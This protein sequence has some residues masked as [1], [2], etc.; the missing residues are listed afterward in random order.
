MNPDSHDLLQR[1]MAGL[2]TDDEAAVLQTRLKADTDL[3]RLYLHYMNLDVALEAQAGSRD[4]VIDLL[5]S[6]PLMESKPASRWH[7]WRP[8]TAAAAGLVFGLFSASMVWAYALP[9]AGRAVERTVSVLTEGFE[10]ADLTASRGFPRQANE[11][12][13]DVSAPVTAESGVAPI[14]GDRMARLE[15][16][17]SSA[18]R[19]SYA[20]RILDLA[21]HSTLDEAETRKVEV[22]VAFNTPGEARPLHYQIRLAAFSQEPGEVRRIWNHEPVLFDTVLQH[23]GRNVITSADQPGWQTVQA[24]L[25]LPPGTRSVV[26]SLAAGAADDEQPPGS[27]YLDNVRVRFVLE[28]ASAE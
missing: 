20:W 7:F 2:L 19:F 22:T 14:E 10:R 24:S 25:E 21:E 15:K 1:H 16:A 8:L 9:M 27:H 13:G 5:R 23:V 3:R 26:I 4:R 6:A 18:R 17:A 12:S 28:Q 11:W